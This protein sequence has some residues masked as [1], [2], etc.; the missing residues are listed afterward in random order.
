MFESN[1][2]KSYAVLNRREL[3]RIGAAAAAMPLLRDAAVFCQVSAAAHASVEWP[4]YAG[5]HASTKYSTLDQISS[6]NFSS[7]KIAWTWRSVEEELAK[8]HNSR[9]GHGKRRR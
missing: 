8:T 5:D 4:Q 2:Q 3:I 6:A 1:D 7:L 9:P